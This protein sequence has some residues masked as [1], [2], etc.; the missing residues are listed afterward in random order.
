MDLNDRT[1]GALGM[2][3]VVVLV[4]AGL[5]GFASGA[6]LEPSSELLVPTVGALVITAAAVG[7]LTALGARYGRWLATPYW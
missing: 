1:T 2:L 6:L 5:Y 7:V 4:L 3:V